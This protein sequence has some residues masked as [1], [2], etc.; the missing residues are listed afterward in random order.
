MD[1][2]SKSFSETKGGFA[3]PPSFLEATASAGP[4]QGASS[5]QTRFAC[6]TLNMTDRMRFINFSAPE[7]S[8]LR[9]VLGS[10]WPIQDVRAYGGADEI[11][12]KGYPWQEKVNGDDNARRLI[13]RMLEALYDMGWVLQAAVD[14]SKKEL[15]K[16]SL[17]FRYQNPPPPPCDWLSISFDWTDKM[18]IVDAPPGDL[19]EA[20][21]AEFRAKYRLKSHELESGRLKLKFHG[22]PWQA[23]GE[24]TVKSR[25]L[26]LSLLGI[27]ERFGYSLYASIDQVNSSGVEADVLVV[28]R[29]K[30][31]TPGTP[32]WHR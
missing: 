24:E 6:V 12:F 7:T 21:V 25:M 17:I 29:Q 28:T 11:K 31:W 3:P 22:Q 4:S 1:D 5:F 2:K 9:G 14:V 26:L 23:S 8:A 10:V 13:R 19:T 16:D 30:G 32:I 15:D 27:L 18:K 20:I